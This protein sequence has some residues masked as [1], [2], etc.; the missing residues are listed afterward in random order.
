MLVLTRKTEQSIMI[1]NEIEIKIIQVKGM[2][3]QAEVKIGIIAPRHISVVRKEVLDE[4][5]Y[6]N[7]QATL[8]SEG[9]LRL[10]QL[11]QGLKTE[12]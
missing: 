5:V 11:I 3:E 8:H 4:V 2:G 9:A 6:E 12:K 7:R 10:K 1:G